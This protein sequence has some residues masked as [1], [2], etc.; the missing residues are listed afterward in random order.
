[1]CVCVCVCVCV[2]KREIPILTTTIII[3]AFLMKIQEIQFVLWFS[4][5]LFLTHGHIDYIYGSSNKH[6]HNT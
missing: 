1:M 6:K 5:L 4:S 2:Y 3:L